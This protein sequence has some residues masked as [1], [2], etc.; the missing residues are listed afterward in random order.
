MS[1]KSRRNMLGTQVRN[2]RRRVSTAK[3]FWHEVILHTGFESQPAP[4]S[5]QTTSWALTLL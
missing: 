2:T 4:P 5:P 1:Q 3:S